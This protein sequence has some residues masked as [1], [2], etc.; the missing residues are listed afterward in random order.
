M[1]NRDCP[2][3][4]RLKVDIHVPQALNSSLAI[5]AA[6]LS[7]IHYDSFSHFIV[8][9]VLKMLLGKDKQI[10]HESRAHQALRHKQQHLT[11]DANQIKGC[12][13]LSNIQEL[14]P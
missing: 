13:A 2:L 12:A 8:V 10:P 5:Y 11:A 6:H 9:R 4:L 14:S 7:A 1:T 3:T